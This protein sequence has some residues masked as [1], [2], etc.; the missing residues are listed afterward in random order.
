M[1]RS[2]TVD[3]S[4]G[5][6]E[7]GRMFPAT[8]AVR[9][10]W[11]LKFFGFQFFVGRLAR[12]ILSDISAFLSRCVTMSGPFKLCFRYNLVASDSDIWRQVMLMTRN[13]NLTRRRMALLRREHITALEMNEIRNW[14][15]G[16]LRC[17]EPIR[18][19]DSSFDIE[20]VDFGKLFCCKKDMFIRFQIVYFHQHK[21][22]EQCGENMTTL[23]CGEHA[24]LLSAGKKKSWQNYTDRRIRPCMLSD[25]YCWSARKFLTLYVWCVR[26]KFRQF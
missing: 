5:P 12:R 10:S 1:L 15:I 13:R 16:L 8:R 7:D 6:S 20:A 14:I 26:L 3:S 2:I 23:K 11:I 25:H 9:T 18:L 17:F 21:M 19:H 4:W 24:V 22:E